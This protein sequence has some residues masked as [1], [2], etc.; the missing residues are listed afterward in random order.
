MLTA[1]TRSELVGE[2]DR[3][4]AEATSAR[5]GLQAALDAVAALREALP[6]ADDIVGEGGVRRSPAA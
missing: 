3:L 5:E 2:L 6:P 1:M 4:L